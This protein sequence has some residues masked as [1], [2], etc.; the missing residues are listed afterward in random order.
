MFTL[1]SINMFSKHEHLQT[2]EFHFLIGALKIINIHE[3][4]KRSVSLHTVSEDD[5][6]EVVM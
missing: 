2:K 3:N 1:A 4:E 5:N 6:F